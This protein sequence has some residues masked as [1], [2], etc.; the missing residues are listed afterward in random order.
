MIRNIWNEI[1]FK[2]RASGQHK[3]ICPNCSHTRK[4]KKDPCLSVNLNE[5]TYN[6]H[7]C[8]ATGCKLRPVREKKEP[9]ILPKLNTSDLSDKTFKYLNEVRMISN[10]TIKRNRI[11]EGQYFMRGENMNCIW[12][13]Y[14]VDGQHT[15][16]KFRS[17]KKQFA[18]VSNADKHFYKVDDLVGQTEALISEGEFDALSWEEAGF[19]NCVSVPDGALQPT[20]NHSDKKFEYIDNDIDK[21]AT[22]ER[23]YLTTDNDAPGIAL[24][25]ELSRRFGRERCYIIDLGEYK[26]A[27]EVLQKLGRFDGCEYLKAAKEAA[28]P[29]PLEGVQTV[30]DLAAS[31]FEI[32][33]NGIDNGAGIGFGSL[34]EH[35]RWLVGWFYL[36]TG[37]PSHGKSS[38]LDQVLCKLMEREWKFAIFSP[39]HAPEL[40]LHRMAKIISGKAFW[41]TE[42]MSS[43]ELEDILYQLNKRLFFIRPD[44]EDFSLDNILK[45][46]RQLVARH[47]IKGLVIDPW[48]TLDHQGAGRDKGDY[49][50]NALSKINVFKLR[51]DCSVF[52][53]AHPTKMQKND[54]GTYKVPT[55][56]NISDSAHFYNKC[57]I[58]ITVYRN[59][60]NIVDV[61]MWKVKFEGLI[62]KKGTVQFTYDKINNRYT[63]YS[64]FQQVQDTRYEVENNRKIARLTEEPKI[65]NVPF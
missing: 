50:S 57:D 65:S 20:Q 52:L 12:F 18:Q 49:I 8:G 15:N 38:W 44:D 5:Q 45:L 24:Q 34:D 1:D 19:L 14:Y 60:N 27:N 31:V 53:V 25:K 3:F 59:D 28:K 29:Y 26:D 11:T 40:H 62:G 51:N 63:E 7:N 17:G 55:G 6:C 64:E 16:T 41:G 42:R 30:D 21:F 9:V 39:E 23:I 22:I 35:V 46:S 2:G 56:Y 61:E 4:D 36:I 48:N 32:Y 37:V 54:D 58:G 47:G 13:N 33:V 10:T 43:D